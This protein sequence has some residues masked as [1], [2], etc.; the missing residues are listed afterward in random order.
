MYLEASHR[1]AVAE[2][3][4]LLLAPDGILLLDPAEHLGKAAHLFSS[5]ANGVYLPRKPTTTARN[6][7]W[8]PARPVEQNSV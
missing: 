5:G 6:R 7:V 1:Y 4:A 8:I 3:L 2:R